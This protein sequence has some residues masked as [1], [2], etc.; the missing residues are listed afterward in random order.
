MKIHY[1]RNNHL[2][3]F[4]IFAPSVIYSF[5]SL[6]MLVNFSNISAVDFF[7]HLLRTQPRSGITRSKFRDMFKVL[8]R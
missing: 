3:H 4:D 1:P 8:D 2:S 7:V 5:T 6:C